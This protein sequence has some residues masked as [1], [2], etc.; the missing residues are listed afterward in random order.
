M[1]ARSPSCVTVYFTPGRGSLRD[2]QRR[3]VRH[4]RE[5]GWTAHVQVFPH[6]TMIFARRQKL[7]GVIGLFPDA[8]TSCGRLSFTECSKYVDGLQVTRG[9]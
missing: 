5:Q 9:S 4:A 7:T 2:L 6:G 1:F 3:I 8:R